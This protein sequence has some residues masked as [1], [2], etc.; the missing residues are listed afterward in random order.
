M[1]MTENNTPRGSSIEDRIN[2]S[3]LEKKSRFHFIFRKVILYIGI[4]ILFCVAAFLLSLILFISRSQR[5]WLLTDFGWAGYQDVFISLPW[6][7]IGLVILLVVTVEVL[8]RQFAFVY[9]RP[10]LYSIAGVVVVIIAAG[11]GV[12][13][14]TLHRTLYNSVQRTHMPMAGSLYRGIGGF[15]PHDV[16]FGVVN[17]Q[18]PTLWH[19]TLR[20]DDNTVNVILT[21]RTRFPRG[22]T[23]VPKD[24]VLIMGKRSD[25]SIQAYGIREIE[26]EMIPDF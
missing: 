7:I 11:V 9:R 4:V 26:P 25:G 20:G 21:P 24:L 10:A 2:N 23:I 5:S 19:V 8:G 1:N 14:T 15:R 6:F 17:D 22:N 18:A 16:Y 13:Q 3:A 12:A